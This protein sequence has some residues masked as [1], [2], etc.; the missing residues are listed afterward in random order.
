MKAYGGVDVQM[1]VLLMVV[2]GQLHVPAAL[3]RGKNPWYPFDNRM[4]ESQGL[5]G[6]CR[7]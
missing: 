7:E 3:T 6:R 1:Q 2:S 4:G 5:S